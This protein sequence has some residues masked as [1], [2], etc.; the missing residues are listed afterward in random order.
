MSGALDIRELGD[1]FEEA[2]SYAEVT[3]IAAGDMRILE[4]DQLG[5]DIQ[6]IAR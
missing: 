2:L 1:M 4:K 5:A 6:K 3:A